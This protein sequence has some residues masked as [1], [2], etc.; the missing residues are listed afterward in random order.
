MTFARTDTSILSRWWWTVD[1]W[2]LV[3]LVI[4]AAF[5]AVLTMAAS[6]AVAHRIGL[7]AFYFARRQFFFLPAAVKIGRAHV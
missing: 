7:D 5:G 4:I 3:A 2:L 1:R 6:P